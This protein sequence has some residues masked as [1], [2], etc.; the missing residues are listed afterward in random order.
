MTKPYL[1]KLLALLAALTLLLALAGC[2]G[3][4][5]GDAPD[6]PA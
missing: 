1:K 3:T 6:D 4:E 5:S 2:G